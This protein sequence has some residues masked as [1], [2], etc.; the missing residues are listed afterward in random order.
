MR[1][2][3]EPC[4][5]KGWRQRWNEGTQPSGYE[6]PSGGG[7]GPPA[8]GLHRKCMRQPTEPSD[9]QTGLP[10]GG[11]HGVQMQSP[12]RCSAALALKCRGLPDLP[13]PFSPV[14]SARCKVGRAEWV[15]RGWDSWQAAEGAAGGS[16]SWASGCWHG[17][18]A[19]AH[20]PAQQGPQL[21][22]LGWVQQ[23]SGA[24]AWVRT[25]DT[26]SPLT[27]FSTVLGTVAPYCSRKKDWG[28]RLSAGSGCVTACEALMAH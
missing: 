28:R 12:C 18:A 27:K 7:A 8:C 24:S 16:T 15:G 9:P 19:P 4:T 6:R 1:W 11:W 5:P 23:T 22:Q 20:A 25:T 13:M 3:E 26:Y 10:P 2:K 17:T 21:G 14:H